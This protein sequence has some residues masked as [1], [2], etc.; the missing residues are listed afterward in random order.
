MNA[1]VRTLTWKFS[2]APPT[3]LD[4]FLQVAPEVVEEGLS[5]SQLKIAIEA[6]RVQVNGVVE[7][8]P[9]MT[10]K[11]PARVAL[12]L[13][14][15]E[16]SELPRYDRKLDLLLEEEEFLVINKPPGLSVHPGAGNRSTTLVNALLARYDLDCSAFPDATRP[17]IVH[18]LDKDTSGALIVAKTPRAHRLLSA[19]FA[20]KAARRCYLAL[21]Y[22][23]PRSKAVFASGEQGEIRSQIGRHPVR[24]QEMAV[25]KEGGKLA[26]TRWQVKERMSYATLLDI[27]LLTGRT[28]QIRVHL[29]H[30]HA[31]IVG[32][33]VYGGSHELPAP[34]RL[35]VENFHRQALHA[36]RLTFRHPRTEA[37]VVVDAPPPAD[38]LRLIEEF[39]R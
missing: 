13:A 33:P 35:T 19:Q 10:L 34:L 32:D 28:H 9:G 27:E 4:R 6:G 26:I 12:T 1:E 22:T 38:L 18:R 8:R 39:R 30:E 16:P 5:R 36:Y 14:P 20:A 23:P 7:T 3:R 15:P 25:V 17:G 31:P 21:A 2:G 24:R 29:A 11:H 37:E